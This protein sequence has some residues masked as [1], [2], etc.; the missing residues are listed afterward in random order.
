MARFIIATE[1]LDKEQANALT[2]CLDELDFQY[3]H[4]IEGF[5]LV[6]S[7]SDT[8][9]AKEIWEHITTKIPDLNAKT[10]LLMRIDEP[11]SYWGRAAKPA[12]DWLVTN[13]MGLPK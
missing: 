5:W 10:M 13:K 12:W 8:Q 1:N 9:T 6:I 4:W 11:I 2:N 3:W 7:K